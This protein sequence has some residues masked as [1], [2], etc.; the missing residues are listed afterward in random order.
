MPENARRPPH[1]KSPPSIGRPVLQPLPRDVLLVIGDQITETPNVI[2][3]GSGNLQLSQLL[4][5]T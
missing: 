1:A 3:V 2:A 4:I 5:D